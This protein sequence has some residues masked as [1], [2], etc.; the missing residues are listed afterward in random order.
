MRVSIM[1]CNGVL[2]CVARLVFALLC[3][4]RVY[5]RRSA[6]L[7]LRAPCAPSRTGPSRTH[8]APS[9]R[10]N[11]RKVSGNMWYAVCPIP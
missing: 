6:R 8:R 2:F 10:P 3:A 9:S 4:L 11:A 5:A 7:R 1:H